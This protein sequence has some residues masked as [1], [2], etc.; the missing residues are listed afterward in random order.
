MNDKKV[1]G[2]YE[3]LQ[4]QRDGD[5]T[6]D[7]DE[8]QELVNELT[9]QEKIRLVELRQPMVEPGSDEHAAL[10]ASGYGMSVDTARQIVKERN[11]RPELWPYE[12]FE[13]A[14]AMLAAFEARDP[15]PSSKR[16]PWK[17]SR[18]R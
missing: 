17:R 16:K 18:R 1:R 15:Q 13:Q 9:A 8:L 11:K 3:A 7:A 2:I 12:K 14:K 5:E 4:A 6:I 10:L